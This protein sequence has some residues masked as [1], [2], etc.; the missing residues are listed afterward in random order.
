MESSSKDPEADKFYVFTYDQSVQD[1]PGEIDFYQTLASKVKSKDGVVLEL[2]SGTGRI[3]IRLAEQGVNVVGVDH[4]PEMILKARMKS[5]GLEN[6][7]WIE[8]DMRA[9]ELEEKVDLVLM[10]GHSFQN[11][12]SPQ[13]QV[14]CLKSV[15]D[16]LNPN[17]ILVVHLDHMNI[18]NVGW[19]GNLC[20]ELGGVFEMTEKFT[21]PETGNQVQAS[22]AWSYQPSTQT[23]IVQTAWEEKDK[24]RQVLNRI[25]RSPIRLHCV[26][27]FEMEHLLARIGF[28]IED[29]FGD[30]FRNPL[31]D[32]SVNMIWIARRP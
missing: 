19:L 27:R 31:Q 10:P 2:A 24:N 32:D 28:E 12:N 30:F 25:E 14:A 18:E 3:A 13:D 16:Y 26:F 20:G 22:R 23:A 21:H 4:S 17:G 6:I 29:V 8:G 11:L 5:D 15:F 1:W 7:R 9:F